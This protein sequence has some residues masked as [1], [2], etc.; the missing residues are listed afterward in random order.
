MKKIFVLIALVAIYTYTSAQTKPVSSKPKPAVTA[1]KPAVKAKPAATAQAKPA[2]PIFKSQFDSASYAFGVSIGNDI[3]SR[4]VT[5][6]NYTLLAKA[7]SDVFATNGPMLSPEKC[8]ELIMSFLGSIEKKKFESNITEGSKF[9]SENSKKMGIVTLP[10]GL[11]YQILT[12]GTGVKPKATDEVTVHYKG[13]LLNGKQFDSSYDRGEPA[14]FMLNQVIPGWTEGLQQM[15]GGSKYRF[16]IPYALAY[17]ERAAG[18]DIPPFST[19]MFEVE[20]IS[21]QPK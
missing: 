14:T 5:G 16:F 2:A 15:S 13:T 10:S 20:L 17:G 3:K 18:P 11:Q 19:L 8:Q 12:P 4:G 1:A 6:L 21:V 9:L 7:L